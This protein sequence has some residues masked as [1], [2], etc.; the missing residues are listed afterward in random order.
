MAATTVVFARVRGL[1]LADQGG[2]PADTGGAGER[3]RVDLPRQHAIQV[4][5]PPASPWLPASSAGD[6]VDTIAPA[7]PDDRQH[8]A[9]MVRAQMSTR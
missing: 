3:H 7:S 9:Q 4:L 8:I 5:E 6:Q 1:L 2:E